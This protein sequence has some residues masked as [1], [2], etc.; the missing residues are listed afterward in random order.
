MQDFFKSKLFLYGMIPVCALCW[1]FSFL[2]TKVTLDKLDTI[3]LLAMRWSIAALI[4][5]V[6]ALCKVIKI[7]FRGK[8]LIWIVSTG[9]LQPCIYS[10]FETK[11]IQ[12]TTASESSIFIAT[13]PLMV[14]LLGEVFFLK[15]NSRSVKISIIMAFAGVLIC[16]GFSPIFSLGG[17]GMGYLML[18]G[19]II[20]GALYSYACSKAS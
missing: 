15:Q 19:A 1:G 16:V 8:P 5:V 18:T 7:R 6:L 12:L 4:F 2:G 20:T 9:V 11:G 14:L 17:K 3:Q 13:I 10:L